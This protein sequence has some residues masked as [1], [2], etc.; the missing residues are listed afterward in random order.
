MDSTS[1]VFSHI[2]L[3][4]AKANIS[5]TNRVVVYMCVFRIRKGANGFFQYLRTRG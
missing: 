4:L 2:H 5:V 1:A 3:Y